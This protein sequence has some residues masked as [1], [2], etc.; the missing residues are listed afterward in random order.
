MLVALVS[1]SA[2]AQF[3]VQGALS[4]GGYKD[5][6]NFNI[7]PGLAARVLYE[8]NLGA[9][10]S[11]EVYYI[12]AGAG[13]VQN[14]TTLK[15]ESD[16]K[17]NVN[18]IQIPV[19]IGSDYSLARGT[20]Y[21][22]VGLYY[23]YALSGKGENG[24]LDGLR[25]RGLRLQTLQPPRFRL[26]SPGRILASLQPGHLCRLQRRLPRHM[27]RRGHFRPQRHPRGR[28]D[29]QVLIR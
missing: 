11:N 1:V 10:G 26:G 3:R 4:V 7:A 29:V 2:F 6:D 27:L 25:Q 28:S 24:S 16:T 22:A 12:S 9:V 15:S 23:G 5:N 17:V 20:I 14:N 21:T 8:Y 18:W 19:M 13:F